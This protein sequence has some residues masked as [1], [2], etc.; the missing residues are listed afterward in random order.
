[1]INVIE[2][3]KKG[4]LPA[5]QQAKLAKYITRIIRR[6]DQAETEKEWRESAFVA[7]EIF[8]EDLS[9]QSEMMAMP[10]EKKLSASKL[11]NV[12]W[13][14]TS[15]KVGWNRKDYRFGECFESDNSENWVS[16]E[17]DGFHVVLKSKVNF[18]KAKKAVRMFL[19]QDYY[20]YYQMYVDW[21]DQTIQII[22]R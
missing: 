17:K 12:V 6:R 3:L 11:F 13:D 2:A 20:E 1:M 10:E 16:T 8:V 19:N 14:A 4:E 15:F 7:A 21:D 9:R 5:E 22:E 18:K